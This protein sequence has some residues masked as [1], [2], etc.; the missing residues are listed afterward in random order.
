[1]LSLQTKQKKNSLP[2]RFFCLQD[3][4]AEV[5]HGSGF[6]AFVSCMPA[7]RLV[8]AHEVRVTGSLVTPT[9]VGLASSTIVP[10]RSGHNE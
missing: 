5:M 7:N 3:R 9:K 2:S 6:K 10:S 4:V 8:S 1:M